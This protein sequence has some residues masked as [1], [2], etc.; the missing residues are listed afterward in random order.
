MRDSHSGRI[1]IG[2]RWLLGHLLAAYQASGQKDE[3]NKPHYLFFPRM[4]PSILACDSATVPIL[5][6]MDLISNRSS[7]ILFSTISAFCS[8]AF[9]ADL[10]MATSLELLSNSLD[11]PFRIWPLTTQATPETKIK[12]DSKRVAT[13]FQSCLTGAITVAILSAVSSI[14]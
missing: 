13:A 8:V 12:A 2:L 6:F 11:A 9:W 4:Y 1:G 3:D 14:I 7:S 10:S 5:V